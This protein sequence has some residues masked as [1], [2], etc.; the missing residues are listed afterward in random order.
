MAFNDKFRLSSHAV[1]IKQGETEPSVLLLKATYGDCAWGL[2]GGSLEA[3]ETIHQA[4]HR[5]CIEELGVVVKINY[6]SGVYYHQDYDS[7]AF[8]FKCEFVDNTDISLSCEHSEY[9][10]TPISRL[11]EVQKRRVEDCL[12]FNGQVMSRK[13]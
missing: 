2:P 10:F 7:Q 9:C 4:L 6:L 11:S 13:F 1:I 8:I 5:E 12:N 3:G